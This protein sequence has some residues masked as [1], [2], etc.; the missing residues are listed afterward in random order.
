[1]R[2]HILLYRSGPSVHLSTIGTGGGIECMA[3]SGGGV[4]DMDGLRRTA[5]V[6]RYFA[7]QRSL[8]HTRI[9]PLLCLASSKIYYM[10]C[11]CCC[12][13]ANYFGAERGH[14]LRLFAPGTKSSE[15]TSY[16]LLGLMLVP[17]SYRQINGQYCVKEKKSTWR[18]WI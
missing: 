5:H 10:L 6:S 8:F 17:E 11:C 12:C 15:K 4:F 3:F 16:A 13:A 14:M 2:Y 18:Q 9:N 1:M 7:G